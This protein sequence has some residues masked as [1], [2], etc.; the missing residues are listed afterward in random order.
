MCLSYFVVDNSCSCTSSGLHC[1]I[2]TADELCRCVGWV[3]VTGRCRLP[4][5]LF[6]Y[7]TDS[8]L[9]IPFFFHSSLSRAGN[10]FARL[11]WVVL[12]AVWVYG[13]RG[14]IVCEAPDV[15]GEGENER[16]ALYI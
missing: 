1:S 7:Y 15:M 14:W 5:L 4:R 16:S 10:L 8:A 13:W 9:Y 3:S 2:I 12:C 6:R 11:D